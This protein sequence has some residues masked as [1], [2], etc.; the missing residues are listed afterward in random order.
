MKKR[1]SL[2]A[3]AIK[4]EIKKEFPGIKVSVR[5]DNFAGGNSVDV[6]VEDASPE[7]MKSL[8]RIV[9]KYRYGHFDGMTDSYEYSNARDDIPQVKYISIEN[10]KSE[11]MFEKL[12]T[13]IK[14]NFG[15]F[16]TPK[17][18]MAHRLFT[19]AYPGFWA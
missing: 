6:Y 9:S 8:N 14:N 4:K 10:H 2:A 15:S 19:G 17:D 18:V 1:A 12:D 13:F 3:N 11:A 5:S 7:M 16:D